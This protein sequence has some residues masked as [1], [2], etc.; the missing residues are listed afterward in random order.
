MRGRDVFK[1]MAS[2]FIIVLGHSA[3][4]SVGARQTVPDTASIHGNVTDAVTGLPVEA[5][6]LAI[7]RNPPREVRTRTVRT[8]NGAFQIDRLFS[9]TATLLVRA[10]GYAPTGAT[11]ALASSAGATS[12]PVQRAGSIRGMV[13]GPDGTPVKQAKLA[14][15]YSTSFAHRGLL[16]GFVGGRL[17]TREDGAFLLRNLVPNVPIQIVARD[18][19]GTRTSI[20]LVLRPGE[21]IE[22]LQLLLTSP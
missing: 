4:Q 7:S 2:M 19:K 9:G 5:V 3:T 15:V 18:T 11:V 20:V 17:E 14:A 16:E 1:V 12:I 22:G 13:V 10:E 21:Q 8:S 6:V